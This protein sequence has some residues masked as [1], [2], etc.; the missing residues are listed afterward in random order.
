M[1]NKDGWRDASSSHRVS[2]VVIACGFPLEHYILT[3]NKRKKVVSACTVYTAPMT[4][5]GN[6]R[7]DLSSSHSIQCVYTFDSELYITAGYYLYACL[8]SSSE[9]V[10]GPWRARENFKNSHR[11]WH[12]NWVTQ[13]CRIKQRN[14]KCVS[15]VDAIWRHRHGNHP[16]RKFF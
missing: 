7:P 15:K 8:T 1:W 2:I 14:G 5:C 16:T 13:F 9:T 11:F 4:Y 12:A 3:N 10:Y 6:K